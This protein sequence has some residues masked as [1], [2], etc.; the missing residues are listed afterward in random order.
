[1]CGLATSLND[2]SQRVWQIVAELVTDGVGLG[3]GADRGEAP[4]QL[5]DG[6]GVGS[7]PTP[8]PRC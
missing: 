6:R 2:H 4:E 8:P 5:P 3:E 1:M 7:A